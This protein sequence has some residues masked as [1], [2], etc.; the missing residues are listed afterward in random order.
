VRQRHWRPRS[1]G[2]LAAAPAAHRQTFLAIEPQQFLR[3]GDDV[4]A[5]EEQTEPSIAEATTNRGERPQALT[6]L[7]RVGN[8]LAPNRFGINLNESAGPPLRITTLRYQTERGRSARRRLGQF[9]P[10]M[11]S[12]AE[13]SSMASASSFFSRRLSSSRPFSFCASEGVMPPYLAFQ[14]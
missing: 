8:R 10:R 13:T 1:G 12:S 7:G 11:S 14:R 2:A 4:L 5:L 3:V 6:Y 9:F